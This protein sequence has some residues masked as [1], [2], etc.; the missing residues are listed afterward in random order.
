LNYTIILI[1]VKYLLSYLRYICSFVWP[2]ALSIQ[3][4][5]FPWSK[6]SGSSRRVKK[7]VGWARPCG[8]NITRPEKSHWE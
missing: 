2:R 3:T 8:W 6:E 1:Q 4:N 7:R 5:I